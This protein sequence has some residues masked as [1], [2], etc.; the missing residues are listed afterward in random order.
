MYMNPLD[1][2]KSIKPLRFALYSRVSTSRDQST[3]AQ[4]RE[5]QQ[6][7][8]ARGWEVVKE[9]SDQG[10]S[11]GTSDRPALKE[12]LVAA[13]RRE[14]D[15]V[16]VTKLD[17]LFRSLKHLVVTLEELQSLGVTFVATRD[18]VD[19]STPSWRMM[20]Q[21]LGSLAEFERSLI[22]ERTSA[23]LAHARAMGK[24]I[25]RPPSGLE[26]EIRQLRGQGKSY[27]AIKRELKVS[28]GSI[29]R[30]LAGVPQ[31]SSN[32]HMQVTD[33]IAST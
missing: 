1:K 24:R 27:R 26:A 12:M 2:N 15:G 23:G 8:A 11:G 29:N 33:N 18:S 17:R 14:I 5:L 31:P 20:I 3:E 16:A 4:V 28:L 25:G 21:V 13:R 32:P 6:F 7:S 22:R 9:F 19:W 30:A 10:Y